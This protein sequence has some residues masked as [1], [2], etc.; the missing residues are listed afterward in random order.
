MEKI[1]SNYIGVILDS[2]PHRRIHSDPTRNVQC[3]EVAEMLP[4][5]QWEVLTNGTYDRDEVQ[6]MLGDAR[7]YVQRAGQPHTARQSTGPTK[8]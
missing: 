8:N 7:H 6:Y 4:L 5:K 2:D 3:G 1:M